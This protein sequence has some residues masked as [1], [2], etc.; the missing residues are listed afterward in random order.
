MLPNPSGW[1]GS[2]GASFTF[3]TVNAEFLKR[4]AVLSYSVKSFLHEAQQH[5]DRIHVHAHVLSGALLDFRYQEH[6]QAG[7]RQ[8]PKQ[9]DHMAEGQTGLGSDGPC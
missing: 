9:V 4:N 2:V 5:V 1:T 3:F 6:V 8:V 7:K